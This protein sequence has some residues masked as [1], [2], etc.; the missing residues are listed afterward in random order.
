MKIYL[1]VAVAMVGVWMVGSAMVRNITVVG[2]GSDLHPPLATQYAG[3]TGQGP[4]QVVLQFGPE[5]E[6]PDVTACQNDVSARDEH[7]VHSMPFIDSTT[8]CAGHDV[9]VGIGR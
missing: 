4:P 8:S 6:N 1:F 2:S 7:Q 9:L 3:L 5:T